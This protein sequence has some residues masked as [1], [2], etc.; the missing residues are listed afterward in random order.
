[1]ARQKTKMSSSS[2][3]LPEDEISKRIFMAGWFALPWLWLVHGM[4][5]SSKRESDTPV[6]AGEFHAFLAEVVVPDVLLTLFP[7][8][9][10][11][12]QTPM[13]R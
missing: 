11:P 3:S 7:F 10:F 5:N 6:G 9:S 4:G 1:M 13:P 2:S 8:C 12:R